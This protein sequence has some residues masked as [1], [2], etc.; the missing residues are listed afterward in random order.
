MAADRLTRSV[1]EVLVVTVSRLCLRP[2]IEFVFNANAS[3]EAITLLLPLRYCAHHQLRTPVTASAEKKLG[4][5]T[6]SKPFGLA[7]KISR[8]SE[9][10]LAGLVGAKT[11]GLRIHFAGCLADAC[12]LACLLSLGQV[13]HFQSLI[14]GSRY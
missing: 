2:E 14:S 5:P 3:R 12:L 4:V 6:L 9:V 8:G 13:A 11:L 1:V 10:E 7:R